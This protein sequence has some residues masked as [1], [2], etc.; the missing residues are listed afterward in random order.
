MKQLILLAFIAIFL[1]S[2]TKDRVSGSGDIITE[3]RNPGNFD[4]VFSSGASNVHITYGDDY[5]VVLKGSD[6]L[7]PYFKTKVVGNHL[8]L[9]YERVNIKHDD[10]EIFVTLPRLERL[11]LSGSGKVDI[12][13]NFPDQ[14]KLRVTISGSGDTYI[15]DE[16]A[17]NKVSV[18]VSGSGKA[19]L[20]KIQCTEADVDISGSGDVRLTVED[21]LKARISGSGKVY[22]SGNPNI[23]SRVSGSGKVIKF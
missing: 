9:S 15:A 8:Y 16:V 12:N 22:Y 7:M 4:G 5:R 18:D 17:Y 10:L 20:E 6:N 2:C 3:T 21:F 1:T 14:D 11:A 23:D 19:S 13:G